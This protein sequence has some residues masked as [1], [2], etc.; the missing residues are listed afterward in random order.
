[1]Q[2][3]CLSNNPCRNGGTCFDMALPGSANSAQCYCPYDFYGQYCELPTGHSLPALLHLYSTVQCNTPQCNAMQ[4]AVMQC[5]AM[6]CNTLR[7][8]AMQYKINALKLNATQCNTIRCT[9]IHSN[10]IQ[11]NETECSTMQ[12]SAK[13][14]TRP[15]SAI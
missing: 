10:A 12:C 4:Y 3:A 7:S 2:G 13:H 15:A 8:N 14:L 5:N 11:C 9:A 1:M 6:Q